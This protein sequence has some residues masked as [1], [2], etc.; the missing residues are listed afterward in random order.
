MPVAP[1]PRAM[2]MRPPQMRP[3]LPP[4]PPQYHQRYQQPAYPPPVPP[5]WHTAPPYRRKSNT[6]MIVTLSLVSV[7]ALTGALI[8][9]LAAT[10]KKSTTS[11]ADSGYTNYTPPSTQADPFPTS[12]AKPTP[13]TPTRTPTRTTTSAETTTGTTPRGP[14]PVY[15]TKENPLF[16]GENGTNTV[17]CNLPAW[18]SDPKAAEAFF[19]AALPCLEAAWQPVMQRANLPYI[20]PKLVFP[21][22]KVW[23][24]GCGTVREDEAAAFYCPPDVA[25]YMPFTGLETKKI[26]NRPGSYLSVFAHEFGHHI[27]SIS[28][29]LRAA[30]QQIYD[31]GPDSAAGLEVS[32]RI[33]LQA[34]CLGGMWFAAAWNGKGFVTDQVVREM[35]DDGYQRG[36]DNNPKQPR[37]HGARK[38]Y[39]SW[40]EQG[41]KK[42]RTFQCNTYLAP[43]NSVS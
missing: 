35:I 34:Q 10:S 18:R 9:V 28:G 40:Q 22:G 33:E 36:D 5:A 32:R 20:R 41:Y 1:P 2:P 15:K 24:S 39:G 42:N 3:P 11:V 26:G 27:Q 14:Q 8:A 23:T 31:L 29:S 4:P 13:S 6:G 38:N 7:L 37:D 17:T 12:A 25:M 43:A 21:T 30:D 16:V 19:T